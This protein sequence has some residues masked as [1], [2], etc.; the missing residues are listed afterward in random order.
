MN[1][2]LPGFLILVLLGG[3]GCAA[4]RHEVRSSVLDASQR[5]VIFA[6]DGA[7]GFQA[8][9]KALL[10]EV[11][12]TQ[13]PLAVISVD[14]THGYGR[15]L[16]D[17][18]DWRHARESGCQL[19]GQ[20][21]AY[22]QSFPQGKV[23]IVAHSA[24]AAV[25]LAAAEDLPPGS[26]DR[27]VLLAPSIS[28]NYDLRPALAGVRESIEVFY[29]TRD[30][31]HLALGVALIGTADGCWGCKAAGRTGFRPQIA[32][33]E[34]SCL[35]AKLRQHRWDPAVSWTGNHGGHYGGYQPEFLHAY[36]FPLLVE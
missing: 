14:W 30:L 9:S 1:K 16:A 27:I 15:V 2:T 36:V 12:S 19:A 28:S 20:I 34:D 29:S 26:I 31:T 8:T 25:G 3:S 21:L 6:A 23:Y 17:Q 18:M 33:P 11:E 4:Y 7:G 35:Y 13:L 10:H 32:N 5:G 24:G 22:R